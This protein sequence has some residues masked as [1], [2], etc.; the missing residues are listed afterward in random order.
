M[1]DFYLID[2]TLTPKMKSFRDGSDYNVSRTLRG[3]VPPNVE[4]KFNLNRFRSLNERRALAISSWYLGS[5]GILL[6]E[7]LRENSEKWSDEEREEIALYLSSKASTLEMIFLHFSERDFFGNLVPLLE[8]VCAQLEFTARKPG[9]VKRRVRRRGY[10]DHGSCKPYDKWTPSSDYS[11]T[12]MQNQI[13]QKRKLQE[14]NYQ[15]L[16]GLLGVF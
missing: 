13:E 6:R 12:E 11:L 16:L 9:R 3:V 10:N 5:S 15:F 14:D 4:F 7:D 8:R 2:E 1:K